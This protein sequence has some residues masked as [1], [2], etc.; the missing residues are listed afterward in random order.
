MLDDL[1]VRDLGPL[2]RRLLLGLLRGLVRLPV[3]LARV[4]SGVALLR[5]GRPVGRLLLLHPLLSRLLAH[6]AS[7]AHIRDRQPPKHGNRPY[8]PANG[9]I[10]QLVERLLCK[11]EAAGSNPA[12]STPGRTS[13]ALHGHAQA[14]RDQQRARRS[15]EPGRSRAAVLSSP[16]GA[17]DQAGVARTARSGP[18][19]RGSRTG[20]ASARARGPSRS[21]NCGT[22][23]RKTERRL[24]V[25]DRADHDPPVN[26]CRGVAAMP[27]EGSGAGR[28]PRGQ[29]RLRRPRCIEVDGAAQL[30]AE[31]A[32]RW[33]ERSAPRAPPR[34]TS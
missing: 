3:P 6:S 5:N 30:R 27:A 15:L 12:G 23:L 32:R 8:H 10:A 7:L 9:A 17:V 19:A 33:D 18:P 20:S 24:R 26:A 1:V 34:V 29:Q 22:K 14:Q 21:T 25:Q 31:L 13:A 28:S 11:Q 4:L 16:C 2:R